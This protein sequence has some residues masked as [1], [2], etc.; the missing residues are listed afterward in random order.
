MPCRQIKYFVKYKGCYPT[1][2]ALLDSGNDIIKE[3]R[4]EISLNQIQ[5]I[6]VVFHTLVT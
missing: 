3:N 2:L 1:P 5:L 6:I 4:T